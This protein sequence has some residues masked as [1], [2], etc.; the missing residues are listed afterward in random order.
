MDRPAAFLCSDRAAF[1]FNGL[2]VN[3]ALAELVAWLRPARSPL[4]TAVDG[5]QPRDRPLG[6]SPGTTAR[7]LDGPGYFASFFCRL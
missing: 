7:I 3:A 2:A 4:A 1:L 6:S 5:P